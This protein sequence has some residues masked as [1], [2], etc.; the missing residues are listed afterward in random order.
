MRRRGAVGL[1]ALTTL[2]LPEA[3]LAHGLGGITDLP[4]PGWLFLVGG[5]T[6]LIVS[7]LALGVLW[8]EPLL[9]GPGRSFPA[10]ATTIV[11]ARATRV[12]LQT[13]SV[14]LLAL[15]W[16]AAAFGSERVILNIAPTFIYVVF[17]VG[18]AVAV[19]LFGN[20]WTV[21]DPWRAVAEWCRPRGER[22]RHRPLA[23]PVSGRARR[24]AGD[25]AAVRVRRLELVYADPADP[26]VLAI[27]ILVYSVVTWSGM[28]VFGRDAWGRNGDGFALYFEL[29]SRIA[30]FGTEVRAQRRVV[31]LRR[32]LSGLTFVDRRRGAVVFVSVM[33]GSVA[34]DGFSRSS[35]WQ[36]RL[37]DLQGELSPTAAERVTMAVN[38]GAAALRDR[39]SSRRPTP[40]RCARPSAR[41]VRG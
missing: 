33:L 10:W 9:E 36:D 23:A 25:R 8:K 11:R 29:L 7:F 21:L 41:Q 19:V 39:S 28:A 20:V 16:S 26:R 18:M 2:V 4:V 24:L 1:A 40:L 37:Y 15:V 13:L 5:A 14:V 32:P 12:S 38:L 6:V 17:W 31:V 27:A 35:W 22:A 34:F 3:A 30:L